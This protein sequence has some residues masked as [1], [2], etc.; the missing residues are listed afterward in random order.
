MFNIVVVD[1]WRDFP[2]D[3]PTIKHHAVSGY[4]DEETD[5]A[6]YVK[7]TPR[8]VGFHEEKHAI[9]KHKDRPRNAIDS[10]R[11]EIEACLYSYE[12]AGGPR[13]LLRI[14]ISIYNDLTFR[15]YN[16][17]PKRAIEM[18]RQVMFDENDVPEKW[19]EDYFELRKR[20]SKW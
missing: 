10:V 14:L 9:E 7:D 11:N 16:V 1:S 17:P 18:I 2:T 6:Y 15:D 13:R 8:W 20:I 4:Y 19:K 5:T 12:M 3:D